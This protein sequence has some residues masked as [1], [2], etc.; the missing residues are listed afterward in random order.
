MVVAPVFAENNNLGVLKFNFQ[1]SLEQ[2]VS[3]KVSLLHQ[4][5]EA[6]E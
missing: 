6:K 3:Y 5:K 2:Q 4:D 1:E